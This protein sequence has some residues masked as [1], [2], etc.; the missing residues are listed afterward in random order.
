MT[1]KVVYIDPWRKSDE[2]LAIE[3]TYWDGLDVDLVIVDPPA[4]TEQEILAVAHDADVVLFAGQYTPFN[5]TVFAGLEKCLLVQR[6]GIGMD[7]VDPEAATRHNIIVSNLAVF[8][9]HEVADQTAALIYGAARQIAL[10]DRALHQGHWAEIRP[11]MKPV[12]RMNQQTLG[13]IGFGRIGKEVARRMRPAMHRIVAHDPWANAEDA[14][15]LDVELWDLPSVLQACDYVSVHVPLSPATR[16]LIGWD[17]LKKMKRS[18][19]FINT[20]RGGVINEPDLIR[21]LQE[22][23]I[24]GAALDVFE[25]EPMPADHP[26]RS[27]EQV[28]LTPHTSG[29]SVHSHIEAQ[30]TVGQAVSNVLRGFLPPHV[31]NPGV[32]PRADLKPAPDWT[33]PFSID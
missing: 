27:M 26:F 32:A 4:R 6:Y 14:A 5:E 22:D 19:L 17:E 2:Q 10:C 23:R 8:C 1:W 11:R 25:E 31:F 30:H 13:L 15:A 29:G 28:T 24:A 33:P 18:A 3:R 7:S 20:S 16:G 12:H 9:V 21:V